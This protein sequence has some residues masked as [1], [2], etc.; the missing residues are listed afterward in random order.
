VVNLSI[1]KV[2]I[3]MTKQT[4]KEK[5]DLLGDVMQDYHDTFKK[6]ANKGFNRG[7]LIAALFNSLLYGLAWYFFVR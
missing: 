2:L 1:Q 6:A 7:F 5:Q 4:L 3:I